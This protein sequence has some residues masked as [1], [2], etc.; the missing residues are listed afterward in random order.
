MPLAS[1]SRIPDRAAAGISGT[2]GQDRPIEPRHG[3]RKDRRIWAAAGVLLLVL[4]AAVAW[5]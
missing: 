3:W 4:L 1:I 5:A 2:D